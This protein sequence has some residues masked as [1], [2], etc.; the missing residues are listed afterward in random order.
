[1][2]PAKHCRGEASLV[3]SLSSRPGDWTKTAKILVA[4]RGPVTSSHLSLCSISSTECHSIYQLKF[5]DDT[6]CAKCLQFLLSN[7]RNSTHCT[8]EYVF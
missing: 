5:I 6:K 1:M 4:D 3:F 8:L 7:C 2:T